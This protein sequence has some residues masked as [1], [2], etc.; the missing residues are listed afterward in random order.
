MQGAGNR[1]VGDLAQGKENDF[2][3]PEVPGT[4]RR[5][6]PFFITPHHLLP[7]AEN[8]RI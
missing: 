5:F 7:L 1:S 2:A 4:F 3:N 6:A 8:L